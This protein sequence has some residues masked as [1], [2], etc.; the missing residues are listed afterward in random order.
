M[1]DY[2]DRGWCVGVYRCAWVMGVVPLSYGQS[3]AFHLSTL[4]YIATGPSLN[5]GHHFGL[6]QEEEF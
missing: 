5:M 4:S 1:S 6:D 2:S 3:I